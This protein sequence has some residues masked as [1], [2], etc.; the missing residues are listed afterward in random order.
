MLQHHSVSLLSFP[1]NYS[2]VCTQNL[3]I[4]STNVLMEK[5]NWKMALYPTLTESLPNPNP[6]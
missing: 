3:E 2:G 1:V 4:S 6:K 5:C